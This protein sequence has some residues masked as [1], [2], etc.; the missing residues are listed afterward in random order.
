MGINERNMIVQ[1]LQL[2]F[3]CLMGNHLSRARRKPKF[4]T[5]AD[6]TVKHHS[7][8]HRWV[9]EI[10]YTATQPKVSCAAT[11]TGFSK[12]CFGIVPVVVTGEIGNNYRMYALM[13]NGADKSL[14]DE[15]FD[16]CAAR[17]QQA[18]GVQNFNCELNWQNHLWTG[19]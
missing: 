9:N 14:C 13:D 18:T 5:V 6:C 19:G 17:C 7:L 1:R 16:K 11:N 10:D 4:C 2:C 15:R 8:L 12:S 3:N